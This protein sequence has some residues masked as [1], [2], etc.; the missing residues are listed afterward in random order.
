MKLRNGILFG[1][2]AL[3]L[4]MAAPAGAQM[5]GPGMPGPGMPG[6]PGWH[7]GP[8]PG[9][10]IGIGL[11]AAALGATLAHPYPYYV[12]PAYVAPESYARCWYPQFSGWYACQ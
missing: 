8:G 9:A 10:A 6:G 2:L 11:G 7:G 3:I 4:G 5:P 12:A 1:S